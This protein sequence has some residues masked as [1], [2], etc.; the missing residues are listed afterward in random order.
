MPQDAGSAVSPDRNHFKSDA[1][2]TLSP[3]RKDPRQHNRR[4]WL[5]DD[6]HRVQVSRSPIS[7]R[8]S[9]TRGFGSPG[10]TRHETCRDVGG[11]PTDTDS[12]RQS[13]ADLARSRRRRG[14]T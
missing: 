3:P 12:E 11:S 1:H 10:V 14:T 13:L 6:G 7:R 8:P 2:Q 5:N 9:V 4:N